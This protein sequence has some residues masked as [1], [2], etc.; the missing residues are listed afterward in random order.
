M[1][2]RDIR[3][4]PKAVMV[5]VAAALLLSCSGSERTTGLGV[6]VLTV[7]GAGAS[8]GRVASQAGLSPA[9]DCQITAG[10]AA[11][12]GCSASYPRGT[13]VTLTAT[14]AIDTS[15]TG[16]GSSFFQG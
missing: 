11:S 8:S 6:V 5:G 9:I 2:R 14:P 12:S 16:G 4:F 13:S 7:Q 3:G 1:R 10:V 15:A